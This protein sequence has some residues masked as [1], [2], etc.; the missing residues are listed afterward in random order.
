MMS[1]DLNADDIIRES[2][3]IQIRVVIEGPVPHLKS[4]LLS[5]E[6]FNNADEKTTVFLGGPDT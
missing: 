6:V 3:R 2:N 5:L 1:F 4:L